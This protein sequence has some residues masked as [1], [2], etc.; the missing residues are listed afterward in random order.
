MGKAAGERDRKSKQ[1][2]AYEMNL[3]D[4]VQTCALPISRAVVIAVLIASSVAVCTPLALP[5][6]AMILEPANLRFKDFFLPGLALSA[7]AFVLSMALLPLLY[8]FFP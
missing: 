4:W 2:T 7:L 8:P 3:C 5:A 1:K 6:N